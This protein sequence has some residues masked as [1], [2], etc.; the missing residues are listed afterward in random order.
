M[1]FY[2]KF[3]VTCDDD[4]QAWTIAKKMTDFDW[5]AYEVQ[6]CDIENLELCEEEDE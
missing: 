3:Y 2:V 6:D 1:S 5:S 4:D